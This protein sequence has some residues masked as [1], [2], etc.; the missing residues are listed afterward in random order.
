LLGRAGQD[1]ENQL[2]DLREFVARKAGEGWELS[3]VYTD[4]ASSKTAERPAFRRMFDD[5]SRKQ[6]DV[7]VFWSLDR[8]SR[9]GT[10]ETLGHLQKLNSYGVDWLSYKEEYLRSI[11]IFRD[12]ILS[13]LSCVAK[14]E[15]VRLSER[16]I[17]GLNRA[18]A[19]GK[20]LGRPK[21]KLRLERV[22]HLRDSGKSFRE[23]AEETGVSAMTVQRLQ[24]RDAV[25]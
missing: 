6:F 22:Q 14:Q 21:A 19:A 2:I 12:A 17:A 8:F 25:A 18:R 1:H 13:I 7:V 15:R 11:G 10:F 24:K 3:E 16:T 5:A 23:I 9:E 4:R 20:V